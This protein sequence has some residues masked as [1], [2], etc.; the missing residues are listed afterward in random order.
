MLWPT[1]LMTAFAWFGVH[2]LTMCMPDLY[3]LLIILIL[4]IMDII[5]Y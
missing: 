4:L 3:P 2:M 1:F 5:K